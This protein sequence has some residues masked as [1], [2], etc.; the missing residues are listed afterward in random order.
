M[1]ETTCQSCGFYSQWMPSAGDCLLF[2]YQ[3]RAMIVRGA[4]DVPPGV[5]APMMSNDDTCNKW[6]PVEQ[7][8]A[9]VH[10]GDDPAQ[11]GGK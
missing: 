2:A 8:R 5:S 10:G 4:K 3:R 9:Y 11:W 6:A 7:V 1:S